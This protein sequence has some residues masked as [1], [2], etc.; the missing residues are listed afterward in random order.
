MPPGAMPGVPAPNRRKVG[1]PTALTDELTARIVKHIDEAAF[2]ETACVLEGVPAA[3]GRDWLLRGRKAI[4]DGKDH[5]KSEAPFAKFSAAIHKSLADF[6]KKLTGGI[7][8]HGKRDW[9]ALAFVARAKYPQHFG[10]AAQTVVV[11]TEE[12]ELPDGTIE[13]TTTVAT[14]GA[15]R[16]EPLDVELNDDDY[17]EAAQML[18][19]RKRLKQAQARGD[20]DENG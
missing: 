10:S 17:A 20:K 9:K 6:E 2:F 16:G 11:D 15:P 19:R 3:T 7:L 12:R 4:R 8:V 5:L 13:E 14:T 1:R 18:L